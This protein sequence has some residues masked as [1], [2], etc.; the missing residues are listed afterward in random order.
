MNGGATVAAVPMY[1]CPEIAAANDALWRRVRVGLQARGVEG[2]ERLTRG[3]DLAAMWLN[4]GLV[5][6]Q[7]CGY[8][9]VTTLRDAVA[10]GAAPSIRFPVA[11]ARRTAASSCARRA[12]RAARRWRFAARAARSRLVQ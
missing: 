10:L 2:P 7:T 4:P 5:F 1:D 3:G 11:T 9:L 6:G 8:P 12:I